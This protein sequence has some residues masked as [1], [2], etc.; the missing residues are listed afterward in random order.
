M[1]DSL[2]PCWRHKKPAPFRAPVEIINVR[3][4]LMQ[5]RWSS[6]QRPYWSTW[7]LMQVDSCKAS[8]FVINSE[9]SMSFL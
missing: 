5:A 1:T 2:R 9:A 6:T 7:R 4:G 8:L 3:A